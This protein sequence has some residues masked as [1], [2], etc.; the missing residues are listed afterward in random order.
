MSIL[1]KDPEELLSSEVAMLKRKIVELEHELKLSSSAAN[2]WAGKWQAAELRIDDTWNRAIH[3]ARSRIG[4]HVPICAAP[5]MKCWIFDEL[6]KM[7][8]GTDAN[9]VPI[10]ERIT[11]A[12]NRLKS[13]AE[14]ASSRPLG[15]AYS[16]GVDDIVGV[17][18]V[19]LS[20]R[21]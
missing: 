9:R 21:E 1:D 17:I 15:K 4:R 6:G 12:A 20:N 7:L 19:L 16:R 14:L 13:E 8:R 5:C 18:D 2:E 10:K 3:E 11:S